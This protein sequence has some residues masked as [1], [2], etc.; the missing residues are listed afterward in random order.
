MSTALG[1]RNGPKTSSNSW[2]QRFVEIRVTARWRTVR[3]APNMGENQIAQWIPWLTCGPVRV[4]KYDTVDTA[5]Q[6]SV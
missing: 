6:F 3:S 1:R 2:A 4:H 5:E